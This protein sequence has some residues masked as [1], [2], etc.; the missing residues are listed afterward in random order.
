MRIGFI[1]LGRMG[2][3]MAPHLLAAGF[4]LTVYN[5]TVERC[6]PLAERGATVA[7]SPAELAAWIDARLE[8]ACARAIAV[9]DPSY[10]T[11]KGILIAGAETDP[12]TPPTGVLMSV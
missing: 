7:A 12:A 6:R 8:A 11:I 2:M 4:D 5:R 3:R 9:G 10:R 1:G